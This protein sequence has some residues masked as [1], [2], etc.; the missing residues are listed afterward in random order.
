MRRGSAGSV[1]ITKFCHRGQTTGQ[2][3]R[4]A[5]LVII[6]VLFG[7][8]RWTHE[9]PLSSALYATSSSESIRVYNA[10][11][12]PLLFPQLY[13]ECGR[14]SHSPPPADAALVSYSK[15]QYGEDKFVYERFFR[16]YTAP[17]IFLEIGALD[18]VRFSNTYG[19]E[20]A[21]GW[22][23][24]LVEAQPSN[25]EA[26]RKADRPHAAIFTSAACRISDLTS[27]GKLRF[28]IK[29]GP[30]ATDLD[31]AAPS[32]LE[33]WRGEHG[34]GHVSVPCI[35]LQYLID[36]TGL[37]DIDFFSLD[38]EGG[39]KV[40]LE[41]VDL[42]QTNIRVLIVELDGRNPEK[43]E[44]VRAHLTLAGFGTLG[45]GLLKNSEVFLN[46]RFEERKAARQPLPIHC[47]IDTTNLKANGLRD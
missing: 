8:H 27:P 45:G 4:L 44:W 46:P 28:S 25:G 19:L 12:A 21:F 1:I 32:F 39:E 15:S 47:G 26:L 38:V 9:V 43:D 17:G 11:M 36:A 2:T 23:G 18:G 34:E 5:V 13:P 42:E 22:K 29:G 41:T 35:P 30:V 40:V 24:I 20:H 7:H 6:I 37:W 31:H 10:L 14:I 33:R 16:N 3:L